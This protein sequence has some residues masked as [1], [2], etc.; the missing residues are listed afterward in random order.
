MSNYKHKDFEEFFRIVSYHLW[1]VK[2][3]DNEQIKAWMKCA[4]EESRE[5]KPNE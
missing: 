5:V 1:N 2:Q 4:F 3:W